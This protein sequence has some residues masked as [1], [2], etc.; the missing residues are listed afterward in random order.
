MDRRKYQRD[1]GG[2]IFFGSFKLLIANVF[3]GFG[4]LSAV[5]YVKKRQLGV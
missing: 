4:L 1:V 3:G 2:C 5:F